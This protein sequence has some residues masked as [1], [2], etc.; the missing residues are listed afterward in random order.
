MMEEEVID[1][2][3]NGSL[4]VASGKGAAATDNK[5]EKTDKVDTQQNCTHDNEPTK[6][7]AVTKT[8]APKVTPSKNTNRATNSTTNKSKPDVGGQ[9]GG[10]KGKKK[11]VKDNDQ[12]NNGEDDRSTDSQAGLDDKFGTRK[13]GRRQTVCPPQQKDCQQHQCGD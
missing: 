2:H 11:K 13:W 5:Q 10:A 12:N 3:L 6:P 7:A 9:N 8:T 4:A 1:T